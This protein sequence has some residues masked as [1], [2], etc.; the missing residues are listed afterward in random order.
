MSNTVTHGS[1]FHALNLKYVCRRDRASRLCH[2]TMCSGRRKVELYMS[3]NGIDRC[4]E[5]Q[6][7]LAAYAL[8]EAEPDPDLISHL[9]R[10]ADCWRTFHSYAQIAQVLPH[11]AP[12]IAPSPGLRERI[13]AAAVQPQPQ[14]IVTPSRRSA[15][16]RW[17]YPQIGRAV[18]WTAAFAVLLGLLSWNAV[19]QA[20]LNDQSRQLNRLTAQV[21]NSRE[22]WQTMTRVLNRSD[23]NSYELSGGSATGR[24]WAS[25]ELDVAC[26]V[27]EGLPDPGAN[28]VYR[29]WLVQ[30]DTTIPIGSFVPNAGSGWALLQIDRSLSAYQEVDV[31]IEP[32]DGN[33]TR[34]GREVLR[35]ILAL[36]AQPHSLPYVET[37]TFKAYDD[38]AN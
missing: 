26:L 15:A 35:G 38:S 6:S 1:C 2:T 14:A 28:N 36:S 9:A 17:R 27:A 34:R 24:F 12:Q 25:P 31:T 30:G 33:Q 20:R 8:G 18:R 29:V 16:P 23:L 4:G 19:L 21:A 22:N 32:R 3:A 10:C 13:L 7:Q 11:T 37:I 5:L